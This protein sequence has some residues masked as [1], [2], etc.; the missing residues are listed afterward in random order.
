MRSDGFS[1]N[2]SVVWS[3]R[4]IYT[5][6]KPRSS[7]FFQGVYV[8]GIVDDVRG[9]CTL[10]KRKRNKVRKTENGCRNFESYGKELLYEAVLSSLVKLASFSSYL[11][12]FLH[13]SL[14]L[15]C[16]FKFLLPLFPPSY[17]SLFWF[18]CTCSAKMTIFVKNWET[19][20]FLP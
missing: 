10:W 19:I 12:F 16:W 18:F 9:T 14:S 20:S 17:C 3:S 2:R 13:F 11:L 7:F 6:G 4:A 8:K 5:A 15:Y 1:V